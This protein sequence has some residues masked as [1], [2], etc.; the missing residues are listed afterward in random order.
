M[1]T[2]QLSDRGCSAPSNS[3]LDGQVSK[4]TPDVKNIKPELQQQTVNKPT[5][6][7]LYDSADDIPYTPENALGEGLGMVKTLKAAIDKL[8]L[9][10]KLRKEVW[11][12]EIDRYVVSLV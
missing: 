4:Q 11:L 5:L 10:S 2:F 12:R 7:Q 9:G 3:T 1:K 8:E 6:Y